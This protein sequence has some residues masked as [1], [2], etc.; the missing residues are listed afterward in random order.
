V[1][2]ILI[3]KNVNE[4]SGAISSKYWN[5]TKMLIQTFD[6]VYPVTIFK[7]ICKMK[8]LADLKKDEKFH[9]QQT[10]TVRNLKS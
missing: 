10:F 5:K 8:I 4:E 7:S 1:I 2:T 9:H 6:T 3:R